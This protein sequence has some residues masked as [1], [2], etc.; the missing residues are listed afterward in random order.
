ME[1]RRFVTLFV[2]SFLMSMIVLGCA[3]PKTFSVPP[4]P[5]PPTYLLG[6]PAPPTTISLHSMPPSAAD[7]LAWDRALWI[8]TFEDQLEAIFEAAHPAPAPIS[9]ARCSGVVAY[10]IASVFGW[11][12]PWAQSI[13]WRESNCEPGA[14][15]PS[16]SAGL[17]Q[18]NGHDDLLV[19]ACPDSD[20]A[21]SWGDA[22]CNIHAAWQLFLQ[23]GARP[24]RL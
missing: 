21:I 15:N 22:S 16:G 6:N 17:F 18:L 20:P 14:R 2:V 1:F 5:A 3:S 13:A 8:H 24:W 19:A 12:S 7:V 10:E 11:A 4:P 9:S 23:E